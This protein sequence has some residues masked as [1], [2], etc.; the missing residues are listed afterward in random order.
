M[1]DRAIY[2]FGDVDRLVGLPS[3]TGKRWLD[4]YERAGRQYEPVLR[5]SSSSSEVVT[6]GE[7][8]EARLL[9]EFR[10]RRVS[11]QRM[12]PAIA[13][14][15]DEFGPYPLAH[16][17]PWLDVYDRELVRKVQVA[18][19]LDESLSLVVVRNGQVVLSDGTRRFR[20]AI[21]YGA[22]GSAE[23]LRPAAAAPLVRMDPARAFGQPMVRGV[24]T[25]VIAE[26]FRAGASRDEIADLYDIDPGLVDQALRFEMI[27]SAAR[28]A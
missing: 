17:R 22:N 14:L 25:D 24:R 27:S 16:A 18:T 26:D 7:L 10:E 11:L 1:L 21:E 19:G 15:R 23:S 5:Q 4:G 2:S 12:R 8:V 13:A 6:W 9:A 3:G 20:E 28:V